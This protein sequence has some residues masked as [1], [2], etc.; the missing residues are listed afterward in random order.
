[1][2]KTKSPKGYEI[3]TDGKVYKVRVEDL[4]RMLNYPTY[5]E[6]VDAAWEFYI[7]KTKTWKVVTK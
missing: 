5:Q 3:V 2:N 6:A 7:E 1:M 4:N